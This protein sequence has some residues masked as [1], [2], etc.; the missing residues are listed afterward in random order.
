MSLV[1]G[2]GASSFFFSKV[3]INHAQALTLT[4]AYHSSRKLIENHKSS[5]R[6]CVHSGCKCQI[7]KNIWKILFWNIPLVS[8]KGYSVNMTIIFDS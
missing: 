7:T 3:E 5:T 8:M 4:V 6:T 1:N 2:K